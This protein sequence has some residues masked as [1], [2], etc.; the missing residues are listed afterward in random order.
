[1]DS[2]WLVRFGVKRVFMPCEPV[3]HVALCQNLPLTIFDNKLK[4]VLN[5]RNSVITIDTF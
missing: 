2:D 4:F 3:V 1:M 5:F